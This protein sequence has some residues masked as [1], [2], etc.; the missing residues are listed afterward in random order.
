[1]TGTRLS[2]EQRLDWLRLIRSENIGPRTFRALVNQYGGAAAAL[3]ALPRIASRRGRSIKIAH[4]ADAEREMEQAARLGVRFVAL[5]EPDYPRTLQAIDTAPPLLAVRGSA[6]VLNRPTVAMVG[7]RNASAA[8]LTF[9]ERL[10]RDLGSAGYAVV[11]GLARGIDARA[12]TAALA[13]GTI[14]VLAGGHDRIYPA[15]NAPLLDRI[16]AEGGAVISEMPL[17]W[18]PRGRDFPRRNRIVSGLS[19]GVVVIEAARRSGSLITAAFALEQGREVFA[20]PGSPLDPRAEGANDLIRGGATLCG[21]AEHVTGVLAPLIGKNLGSRPEAREPA[22]HA[23]D[24]EP[25]WDELDLPDTI[26]DV[27]RAPRGPGASDEEAGV[28]DARDDR[29]LVAQ[30]LGPAP[31]SIDD[32]ARQSGLPVRTIQM[33]LLELELAGRIERHGGNAVSMID[34][35]HRSGAAA[36]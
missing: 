4:R 16:I 24:D 36:P 28:E 10:A 27:S 21:S 33:A 17:E 34:A 3:E 19:Y 18:E 35:K 9:T 25:L 14:A 13:T 22:A 30:L 26:P 31:V 29:T 5:G 1:M 15:E 11:S 8:G 32:L 12:H 6:E 2:G 7:S 20:V 23:Y